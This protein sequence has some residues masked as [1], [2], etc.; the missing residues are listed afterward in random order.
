MKNYSLCVSGGFSL[1]THGLPTSENNL[2][3]TKLIDELIKRPKA[4]QTRGVALV[5]GTAT[6]K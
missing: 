3:I 1:H 4:G 6:E 2:E 5:T